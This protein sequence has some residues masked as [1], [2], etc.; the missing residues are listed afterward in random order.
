M[1]KKNI[2][3]SQNQENWENLLSE[4]NYIHERLNLIERHVIILKNASN[5]LAM[6]TSSIL[7]ILI[8]K[9]IIT[10]EEFNKMSVKILKDAKNKIK[11]ETETLKDKDKKALYDAIINSEFSG[12]A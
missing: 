9:K 11:K 2:I 3:K 8:K 12:N 6:T 5:S 10:E 1:A 7:K 4:L